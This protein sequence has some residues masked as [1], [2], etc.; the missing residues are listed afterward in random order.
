MDETKIP[1]HR[2]PRKLIVLNVVIAI[3]YISW[4]FRLDNAGNQLLYYLLFLG[5]IYH[6]VMSLSFWH[7]VWPSSIRRYYRPPKNFHPSIDVF[8]TVAGEPVEVVE[9]T[10]L[11]AINMTYAHCRIWVLNDGYVAGKDNWVDIE[12]LAYRLNVGCITRKV[13]GGAKAGN[14]NHALNL[15]S[16]DLVVIF[17]ADMVPQPGFLDETVKYFADPQVGFVQTPQYYQNFPDNVVTQGAW[18][19]QKLF[20]GPI[21]RGKE[22]SNAVFI[23]GTNVVIRRSAL[24]EAGGMVEDNIAEDFLTSLKIHQRGWLS[25]YVPQVLV[26]G[27]APQ[28]LQSYYKQQFRWARGSLEVLFGQNPFF[29]S[30][31]SFAQKIQYLSSSLYYFNGVIILIDIIMPLLNLFFGLEPVNVSTTSFAIFFIPFMVLNLYTLYIASGSSISFKTFSL[32]HS[33]W[34]LQLTAV[35]AVLTRRNV[36]FSV[37]PKQAQQGNYLKLALPHLIYIVLTFAAIVIALNREGFRPSV[38]TNISWALFN[39]V[40]FI[41]FVLIAANYQSQAS[42]TPIKTESVKKIEL[43]TN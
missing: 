19:Q 16:A 1:Y 40:L 5:E 10:I 17:D 30:G 2:V 29:K 34:F 31:L 36:K 11:G 26:K 13:P 33:L 41:P 37:T 28:D 23:C 32:S 14:I 25:Y 21:L 22:K 27:L 18:D 4:W 7:T 43:W 39:V 8:I 38:V 20:F 15:T 6:L 35:A 9:K 42:A 3:L 24:I 12:N